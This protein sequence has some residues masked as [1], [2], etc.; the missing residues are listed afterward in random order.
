MRHVM[1]IRT[2]WLE[3]MFFVCQITYNCAD[4]R[5]QKPGLR[6]REFVF[7]PHRLFKST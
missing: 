2:V 4:F 6:E 7:T 1:D 3:S 5:V